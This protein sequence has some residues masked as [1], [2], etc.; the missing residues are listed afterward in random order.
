MDWGGYVDIAQPKP[1]V[2]VFVRTEEGANSSLIWTPAGAIVID[3]TSCP[4]DMGVFL[5]TVGLAPEQVCLV[6]NTHHH[7]DHTWGNQLFDC[8][9]I[10]H[11]RCQEAMIANMGSAWRLERIEA[12]IAAR[13]ASDPE[14]SAEMRKK[15]TG[16]EITVPND[17]FSQGRELEIGG[18]GLELLHF[19]GHTPGS[20]VVWLPDAQIA[21]AGDLLFVGRY[22]YIGDADIPDLLSALQRLSVLGAAVIVPGHGPLCDDLAISAMSDYIHGTWSRTIDHLAQGHSVEQA[23]ADTGYPRYAP[24]AAERYHETNI[25]AIYDQLTGHG[26]CPL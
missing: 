9:I 5:D 3:T 21:W 18:V 13:Q 6:I 26:S 2:T 23:V 12:E 10:A 4:S 14:W 19:G 15:T 20:S 1:G 22:P 17:V 7:S 24:G 25:R 8:P 16:L 11:R